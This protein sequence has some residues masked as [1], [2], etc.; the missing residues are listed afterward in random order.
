MTTISNLHSLVPYNVMVAPPLKE[1]T[2][3][4]IKSLKKELL[5]GW[6]EWGETGYQGN[7]EK[8]IN[9]AQDL[10]KTGKI[11]SSVYIALAQNLLSFLK[12]A[13]G[14]D[15]VIPA[16]NAIISFIFP[17]LFDG[18]E[19]ENKESLFF[20]M[21]INE[22]QKMIDTE[23]QGYTVNDLNNYSQGLGKVAGRFSQ[24]M[25]EAIGQ[26]PKP[27]NSTKLFNCSN[28]P[29][30]PTAK[31]LDAVTVA[32]QH[33]RNQVE[34]IL[35]HFQNPKLSENPFIARN[36]ILFT[37]PMYVTTVTL[38]L[39][40]G[41]SYIEFMTKW[42]DVYTNEDDKDRLNT[43]LNTAKAD[44]QKNI[45]KYSATVFDT[46]KKF[47][48]T[49]SSNTKRQ[50]QTYIKYNR[51][52]MTQVFDTVAL[53][54]SFYSDDYNTGLQTD[55]TRIAFGDMIGPVEMKK[56]T[57]TEK[58]TTVYDEDKNYKEGNYYNLHFQLYDIFNN[59][60]P[61]NDIFNY[62]Y[63]GFQL[64]NL[65]IRTAGDPNCA[66]QR[67][68]Y[69]DNFFATYQ[70]Y[71]NTPYYQ[72]LGSSNYDMS[73]IH[74]PYQFACDIMTKTN[75]GGSCVEVNNANQLTYMNMQ[76]QE[77]Q[78][79]AY[80][81]LNVDGNN[82]AG[83]QPVSSNPAKGGNS[84]NDIV[85][86]QK[87][88]AVYGLY[89]D[90][91]NGNLAD[92]YSRLAFI[93]TLVDQDLMPQNIIGK[94][95]DEGIDYSVRGFPAE[96]GTLNLTTE[97]LTRVLEPINSA[98]AVNLKP[99]QILALPITNLTT[100]NYKIRVRYASK[101]DVSIYFHIQTPNGDLNR[102]SQTLKNTEN[103]TGIA[104]QGYNGRYS[105]QSLADNVFL[106][107]G[108]LTVYIQNNSNS[109]LFLDRIE[110]IA[111]SSTST[112]T[113]SQF[114]T[115]EDLENITNQ[116]NQLF[117]SSAQTELAQTVT[118]YG[119][120][121]VVLKVNALSDDIF[122]VEKKALR[123]LV[124][125]AKQLSKAR[126]VLV[127][128]NFEKGHE[129]V[130]GREATTVADH[131]LFKGDHLLLPPPTMY[132]SYAYQKI[133][134]SKLKSNTR[135]TVSGF[136]A[137]SE[138]LEVV[139]SRYGKEVHDMLDVPYEEALPITSDERPNCCKPSACQCPS[140]N[141]DAPDSHFFSYSIDVGSLQSDVNLGI[142]FGLR[143]AKSNGFAKISN[144]EIKED[145]PL[146]DQEIKKVQR[147]EQKWK[148]AF[149]KEQAELTATLQPTLNQI[150]ALYQ[151]EDWN[152][153]IHPHVTYQHLSDVVVPALPKQTHWFMEDRE[154]EHVVLTQQF[155]QALDRAFQQIEEQN[156]IHN[157]SFT[158]GLT[159]WTVTGDAQ[160]TIYDEDPVLELAHWDASVSQTIE[161][162]DFEE[163]KEYKLRVRGKGKGTV[164][165]QHGEEELETMTFNTS[166]FTTQEQ[167]FYF[168]GNT[169]DI[170]VQSENNT[171]LV[172][173][174]ELIEVVEE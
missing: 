106:P 129:W 30:T 71:N 156:L 107:S 17:Y 55:Q 112:P 20:R 155:Q 78:Y 79:L 111:L 76:S 82:I 102:G 15:V 150:N 29:C 168:E 84:E 170:H 85:G 39:S 68:C 124:N 56:K 51:V 153:S 75:C 144:L 48:P 101:S 149:D 80:T 109:D 54:P 5:N 65:N 86:T 162:I 123:K 136:V 113:S 157:G 36:T 158:S 159:D 133:D 100:Q 44:L 120:D 137:Q 166:N 34:E 83:C 160:I 122:G 11:N 19:E 151:N 142:E 67:N 81:G 61:N 2:W 139:V 110:F 130:L 3:D 32:Y 28:P 13:P 69:I 41:Q 154:G 118:D 108:E 22:V 26:G 173:S 89:A 127:G 164:T 98:A 117:T 33:V 152:G 38:H 50:L 64:N 171:F 95:N 46:Y 88:Q 91:A 40:I 103:A 10:F 128:G 21:I 4:V 126:N 119:I 58:N 163:E 73:S 66:S 35:P 94:T 57:T 138:H 9:I 174:V 167:T 135:Y 97:P 143:I 77:S 7:F 140:C 62:F 121:Q 116:V 147:K 161:I 72:T 92:A 1:S 59:R 14:F 27:T 42:K 49:V 146:T 141:G 145:R 74:V 43:D 148:K 52:M 8:A 70:N 131:D 87:I 18:G 96:K 172:D 60:L 63:E 114:T 125:Q 24:S 53:W 16:G 115:P 169:V 37:L 23:L 47:L 165:V 134:E 31:D 93:Y 90:N 45:I 25:Q 6:K 104:I 132:P 99:L 12:Y 105:L